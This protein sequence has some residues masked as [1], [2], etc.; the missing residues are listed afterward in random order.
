MIVELKSSA[1]WLPVDSIK[2][3]TAPEEKAASVA[4][5]VS[6][7]AVRVSLVPL[8]EAVS[9]I[10]VFFVGLGRPLEARTVSIPSTTFEI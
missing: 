8:I 4:A 9:G 2:K 3:P 10:K 1:F 5:I 6:P 7:E